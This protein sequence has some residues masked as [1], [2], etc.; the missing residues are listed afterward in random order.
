MKNEPK[1]SVVTPFYNTHEYL[2]EAIESVLAQSYRNFEYLLVNNQ[3]T[4]GSREIALRYAAQDP[5]IRLFDNSAFVGQI[6]NYNGAL[7][8]VAADAKYVKMV[9]ADDAIFPDC[10]RLMVAV[11]E[12]NPRIGLV[13]SYYLYGDEPSGSGIPRNVTQ[14]SGRAVCRLMLLTKKFVVGTPTVVMYRA[15]VVRARKPFF[16][17]GRYHADTELAY[18]IFLEHDF[19]FVPQILSFARADN[20]SITTS[21]AAFNPGPLDYL[22]VI[23]QFGR[24]CLSS[25][26]FRAVSE[27]EWSYYWGFLG[28]SALRGRGRDF[29]DYHRKGLATID[30]EIRI[31]TI[32]AHTLKRAA[33]L[34]IWP[35]HKH[36]GIW[37]RKAARTS[38]L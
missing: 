21:R 27:R 16:P 25:D 17:L 23:E 11:A 30:R 13:S 33:R 35:L 34:A 4:D 28:I 20:K 26:E 24:Q 7:E 38:Q 32:F 1:V 2:A 3:S 37:A 12:Q 5:R 31:A 18:A 6:E 8:R 36:C 9:L 19:G 15:D 10:L 22:I 14:L 29:W